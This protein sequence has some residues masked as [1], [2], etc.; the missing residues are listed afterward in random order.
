M[1]YNADSEMTVWVCPRN[2]DHGLMRE[3]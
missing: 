3:T 2:V 1:N